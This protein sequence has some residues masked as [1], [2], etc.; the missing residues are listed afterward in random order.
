MVDLN[1]VQNYF[2]G[3]MRR[4]RMTES[5]AR[6]LMCACVGKKVNGERVTKHV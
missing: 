6:N 1:V 3:R 5:V 4:M 2:D